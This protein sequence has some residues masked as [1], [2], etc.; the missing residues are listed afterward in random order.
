VEQEKA[1]ENVRDIEKE[2]ARVREGDR[3]R[4]GGQGRE[5]KGTHSNTVTTWQH[6]Y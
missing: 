3:V 5:G 2:N 1:R 6:L 4:E